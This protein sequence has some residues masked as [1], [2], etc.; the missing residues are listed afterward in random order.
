M[1]EL[2]WFY[3]HKLV[4]D[5]SNHRSDTSLINFSFL[6]KI[7]SLVTKIE[8]FLI[9]KTT[10]ACGEVLCWN[11][12]VDFALTC[13]R[14]SADVVEGCGKG[15]Y[16]CCSMD[17]SYGFRL[18][19]VW[20]SYWCSGLWMWKFSGR[21][22]WRLENVHESLYGLVWL[23]YVV[24]WVLLVALYEWSI[25]LLLRVFILELCFVWISLF[26]CFVYIWHRCFVN[27]FHLSLFVWTIICY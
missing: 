25:W 18:L 22:G 8:T 23:F 24:V 27:F 1:E 21:L 7:Y 16:S 6:K 12:K 4:L 5:K 19:F 20:K 3:H 9:K 13:V 26:R 2:L 15:W 10:I 14:R 11:L 17:P